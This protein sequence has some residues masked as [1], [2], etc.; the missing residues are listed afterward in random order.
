MHN[1]PSTPRT[2]YAV[3]TTGLPPPP[4]P[5]T[6]HT[7]AAT[8]PPTL[9]A[10]HPPSATTRETDLA[11]KQD[12]DTTTAEAVLALPAPAYLPPTTTPATLPVHD[13]N[14]STI[15]VV[16]PYHLHLDPAQIAEAQAK[17]RKMLVVFLSMSAGFVVLFVVFVSV[18]VT[19]NK[20]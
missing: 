2:I 6:T 7:A 8:P 1:N 13:P 15:L 16:P 12:N 10:S 5:S 11:K 20:R 9:Y 17:Q 18:F 19:M 4:P 14:A 3:P